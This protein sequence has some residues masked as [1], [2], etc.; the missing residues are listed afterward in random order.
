MHLAWLLL[1]ADS[2]QAHSE[3]S[4][5]ISW[6][7]LCKTSLNNI[8]SGVRSAWASDVVNWLPLVTDLC[9]RGSEQ[10]KKN[11]QLE[12]L[13]QFRID[14]VEA[15]QSNKAFVLKPADHNLQW[16]V[17]LAKKYCLISET[18]GEV[19]FTVN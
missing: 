4:A 3:V 14:C 15:L 19:A 11:K 9:A 8:A 12:H 18:G 6:K 1:T 17:K 10:C 13:Q 5:A 7:C 2:A 16:L